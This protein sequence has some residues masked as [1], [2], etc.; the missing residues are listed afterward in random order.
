MKTRDV[1]KHIVLQIIK[2]SNL[3][4]TKTEIKNQ[5]YDYAVKNDILTKE[6]VVEFGEIGWVFQNLRQKDELIESKK[7]D[8]RWVW[9]AI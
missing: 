3:P 7:I 2:N 6:F 1:I 4:K 8:R 5:V 9:Y